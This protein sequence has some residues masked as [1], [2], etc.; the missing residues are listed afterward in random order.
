MFNGPFI[1]AISTST[2]VFGEI[3]YYLYFLIN[4]N[5][6]IKDMILLKTSRIWDVSYKNIYESWDVSIN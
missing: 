6:I 2:A 1:T 4:Y 3:I 5:N